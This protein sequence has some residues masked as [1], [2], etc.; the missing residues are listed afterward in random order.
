M[1]RIDCGDNS[2]EFVKSG[3]RGGMRTNGG[4]G[5]LENAGFSRSSV[6]AAREMLPELLTLRLA[7]AALER[8]VNATQHTPFIPDGVIQECRDVLEEIKE[9]TTT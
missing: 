6:K 9:G 1:A 4:C 5:C 2:C 7:V 3:E 8:V